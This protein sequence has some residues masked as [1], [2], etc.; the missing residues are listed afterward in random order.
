MKGKLL[1]TV[2]AVTISG[3]GD[4]GFE[5]RMPDESQ[6]LSP[7][8][9][10]YNPAFSVEKVDPRFEQTENGQV[11]YQ[12]HQYAS[13]FSIQE[14]LLAGD[15]GA[16]TINSEV[17]DPDG[18]IDSYRW[19]WDKGDGVEE[20]LSTSANL[21][22]SA[23]YVPT[24]ETR[25]YRL[26]V[27]DNEGDSW[28]ESFNVTIL[29][30]PAIIDV[31]KD[32][33]EALAN[34]KIQLAVEVD[35]FDAPPSEIQY[36]WS[37][38][39]AENLIKN[40][41]AN[42]LASFS[43]VA[44]DTT[45]DQ[46]IQITL[47]ITTGTD[48]VNKVFDILTYDS[49]EFRFKLPQE[50]VIALGKNGAENTITASV[51]NA[52]AA[53]TWSWQPAVENDPDAIALLATA[54]STD[55][56]SINFDLSAKDGSV[57]AL[58]DKSIELKLVNGA[59]ERL[60]TVKVGR[61]ATAAIFSAS[62][63]IN[64]ALREDGTV[65]AWSN[66]STWEI[67]KLAEGPNKNVVDVTISRGA[68]AALHMDGTVTTVGS[69]SEG[70]VTNGDLIEGS[71]TNPDLTNIVKVFT[72]HEGRA[73]AAL[74]ANGTVVTW[75][76]V[77]YGGDSSDVTARITDTSNPVMQIV[78][79]HHGF[80]AIHKDKTIT[81]WGAKWGATFNGN[82]V[83]QFDK[84]GDPVEWIADVPQELQDPTLPGVID[85][86]SSISWDDLHIMRY[87][88]LREDGSFVHWGTGARDANKPALKATNI[89]NSEGRKV[90]S[91]FPMAKGHVLVTDDE[92]G[93]QKLLVANN[94]RSFNISS[95]KNDIV[96]VLPS[97]TWD[98]TGA[99][100]TQDG[101]NYFAGQASSA[102]SPTDPS[103]D[104]NQ[105]VIDDDVDLNFT[106]AEQDG[107]VQTM[108][109]GGRWGS[110]LG[111]NG[112]L[113]IWGKFDNITGQLNDVVFSTAEYGFPVHADLGMYGGL[114]LTS[115]GKV[116]SR[117]GKDIQ[118]MMA[119]KYPS[120]ATDENAKTV[121]QMVNGDV[122][123]ISISQGY[124]SWLALRADGGVVF[125]DQEIANEEISPSLGWNGNPEGNETSQK[126]AFNILVSQFYVQY[127]DIDTDN[128]GLTNFQE[129]NSCKPGNYT[130]TY[131]KP[132][133]SAGRSDTDGDGI[134]DMVEQNTAGLEAR[135][136]KSNM[137][138]HFQSS[139]NFVGLRPDRLNG[140]A[141]FDR[142]LMPE[143]DENSIAYPYSWIEPTE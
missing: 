50:Q 57:D 56:S 3:C 94:F 60:T 30:T 74:K 72:H 62:G 108:W 103:F 117:T 27:T 143:V 40:P 123:I 55:L 118:G 119:T 88:A 106:A 5:S 85:V 124:R 65:V 36:S 82:P 137:S 22:F 102:G 48:S 17:I 52:I 136:V 69:S 120:A 133:L 32:A 76:R 49:A 41:S 130:F 28:S 19:I 84:D 16:L 107:F 115:K 111:I 21:I 93:R 33:V 128:D 73:F 87:I 64:A 83:T 125:N 138:L 1:I 4:G 140:V 71:V 132:C 68:V 98:F 134:S 90:A 101:K 34:E 63:S 78:P 51:N 23:E 8:I 24:D 81:A 135:A 139:R 92:F 122:P 116:I 44:P 110:A 18:R 2:L 80:I 25:N 112:N 99:I 142:M 67:D 15:V 7:A 75:G 131:G 79:A 89:T 91:V 53:G 70:G 61:V 45:N 39:N 113:H 10:F 66:S 100:L 20:V 54:S 141:L 6:N 95:S 105:I 12:E 31:T 58:L 129:R 96:D 77:E 104:A 26:E 59:E 97:N 126:G 127:D 11:T 38:T 109:Y 42:D 86:S 43:F 121:A 13:T 35:G 37:Q 29:D 9:N 46:G 114:F 14:G 47:T